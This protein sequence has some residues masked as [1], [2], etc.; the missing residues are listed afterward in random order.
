APTASQGR[1]LAAEFL[2]ASLDY[3]GVRFTLAPA[4]KLNAVIPH[5]ETINLPAGDFTRVYVLAASA[6]ADQNVTFGAGDRSANVT[7]QNWTGYVGQWDNR[8]WR[9][10]DEQVSVPGTGGG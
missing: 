2:P 9:A 8:V 3:N 6:N 5:G 10:R 7:I 4:N 1:A